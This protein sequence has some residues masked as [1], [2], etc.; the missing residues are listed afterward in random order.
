MQIY[1]YSVT[2]DAPLQA[3]TPQR[4]Q[5]PARGVCRGLHSSPRAVQASTFRGLGATN[6]GQLL[7]QSR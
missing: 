6:D 5:Q 3:H 2:A 7:L 4:L 1:S